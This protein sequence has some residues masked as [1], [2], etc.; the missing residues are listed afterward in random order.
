MLQELTAN[1]SIR[2]CGNASLTRNASSLNLK[3]SQV[4]VS[5]KFEKANLPTEEA[6]KLGLEVLI[7]LFG[8]VGN[9][10]VAIVISCMGKKKK[11]A[12]LYLLNLAIADLGILLLTFP[13]GAIREKAPLNW[14]L[15]EF[16]CIYLYPITEIFHGVSVWSIGVIAVE[17]YRKIVTLQ[18]KRDNRK[19]TAL[20]NPK[21]IVGLVWVISFCIFCFPLYFVVEYVE[22]TTG[23]GKLC[24][25]IWPSWDHAW[26]FPRVYIGV[27]TF[28]SYILPLFVIALTYLRIA[29]KID[30]SSKFIKNMKLEQI[31]DI[32]GKV[33]RLSSME[34]RRLNQNRRAMSG[35]MCGGVFVLSSPGFHYIS[36]LYYHSLSS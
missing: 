28:F 34:A 16:T 35:W 14:P 20:R 24:G 5:A 7:A 26:V 27:L 1:C 15:G 2:H 9:A 19:K 17:R 30:H 32:S 13:L 3:V 31:G 29:R 10:L 4:N 8:V 36:L 11:P 23:E 6:F 33:F 25:P 12:D 21:I 22:F 18:P